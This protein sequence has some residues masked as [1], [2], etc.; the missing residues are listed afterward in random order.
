MVKVGIIGGS[1]YTG[2]E[3]LRILYNH[4]EVEI[5]VVTS[6]KNEGKPISKTH[7]FL[8]GFYPEDMKFVSPD[9]KNLE[10]CDV[11][12]TAVP[13]GSAMNY[14]PMLL[15]TGIKVV[16]ISADYRLDKETYERVYEKHEYFI[17]AVYGLTELYSDEVKKANLVANPGCYPTGAILSTAPLAAEGIVE[18]V[19]FD[20]KSGISGAGINP[21]ELSH[22][23]N[24]QESVIPYKIT[25][26]RH[27]YEMVQELSNLQGDVKVSF[28]PQVFPGSRGILTDA[29]IFL[30][31]KN[32][33]TFEELKEVYRT[34][35]KNSYF[36]R[37]QEQV[38]LS[39]VRGS[40]FCDISLNIGDDRVVVVSAIDNLV[41]GASGQAVQNMNLMFG[42]D[43][44]TGLDY[45]PTFP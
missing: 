12:F 44:R 11:A 7:P 4:P 33:I 32:P 37:L 38:R 25:N 41:K 31:E 35:Y 17:E 15:D 9:I 30:K 2:S 13:H 29:H 1:G 14:V 27:Y 20:S 6:R 21:K 5:T 39:W 36:V 28:T 10:D 19:V 34:F 40:N 22:Y 45:P 8:K 3:L 23:P 16:D 18:R 24:L 42:L 26:H 43:E